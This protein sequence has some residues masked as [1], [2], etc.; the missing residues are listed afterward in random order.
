M[1]VDPGQDARAQPRRLRQGR[2][3]VALRQ[4]VHGGGGGAL[5]R[6]GAG[7]RERAVGRIGVEQLE[8][9]EQPLE[10]R[11]RHALLAPAVQVAQPGLVLRVAVVL[12]EGGAEPSAAAPAARAAAAAEARTDASGDNASA[13]AADPGAPARSPVDVASAGTCCCEKERKEASERQKEKKRARERER[14]RG[15]KKVR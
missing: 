3:G 4:V 1:V 12:D 2:D 7:P 8:P 6:E 5:G 10:R 15:G 14:E 11:R 13:D 9:P